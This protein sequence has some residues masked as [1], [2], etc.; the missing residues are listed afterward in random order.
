MRDDTKQIIFILDDDKDIVQLQTEYL[1]AKIPNIDVHGFTNCFD[2]INHP[3]IKNVSLCIID[4][5]LKLNKS[6][7]EIANEMYKNKLDIPYL[8]MSGKDYK[9]ECFEDYKFTYDFLKKPINLNM[10]LIRVKILLK[11]SRNYK[12]HDKEKTKLQ[13][14]LKELFDYTNI[15]LLILDPDMKIKMCSYKL[16]TDLGFNHESEMIG[17]S[18]KTFIKEKDQNKLKIV[19]QNVVDDTE[20]YQKFLREVTN[21]IIT[22]SGSTISVKWFNSRIR[23]GKVYTFSI[24]IPYNRKVTSSDDI[25]SIRSY[26]KHV[27]DRDETTLKALKNVI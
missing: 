21:K 11:V 15:Y 6:G 5:E 20:K 27:L 7:N 9:F 25:D 1:C 26:W 10:L 19:F 13:V 12:L 3:D 14:S 24:G 18:W 2:M 4:I 8:F 16:G 23:N 17:L 22:K